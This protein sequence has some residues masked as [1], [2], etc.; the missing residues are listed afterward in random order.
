MNRNAIEIVGFI[1]FVLGIGMAWAPAALM[2]AGVLAI[3]FAQSPR[4]LTVFGAV[5]SARWPWRSPLRGR[6]NPKVARP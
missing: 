6:R 1:L 4:E 5:G 3:L 2:L